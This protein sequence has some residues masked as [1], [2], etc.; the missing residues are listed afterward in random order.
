MD[1]VI[2]DKEMS[3]EADLKL[4]I[5]GGD[6]YL[7]VIYASK[8]AE[9]EVSMKISSDYFIDKLKA[10]IPGEIDDAILEIFKAALKG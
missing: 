8:G 9:G 7:G 2:L 6:V 3:S 1:K 5:R 10:A 4:E